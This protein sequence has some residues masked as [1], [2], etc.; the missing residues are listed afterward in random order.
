MRTSLAIFDL[1]ITLMVPIK[2]PIRTILAIFDL[3]GTLMLPTK[4]VYTPG[5]PGYKQ[6]KGLNDDLKAEHKKTTNRT[7]MGLFA[8]PLSPAYQ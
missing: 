4:F 3:Q 5:M 7:M 6:S 8:P 1:Q 2:F